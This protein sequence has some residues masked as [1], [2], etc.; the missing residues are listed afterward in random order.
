MLCFL[1]HAI[2][3]TKQTSSIPSFWLTL[4]SAMMNKSVMR[5]KSV[6]IYGQWWYLQLLYASESILKNS[7]RKVWCSTY[8]YMY[9]WTLG[10]CAIDFLTL[11]WC[12]L[13]L[14]TS[15]HLIYY[16]CVSCTMKPVFSVMRKKGSASPKHLKK[17]KAKPLKIYTLRS[18]SNI[19]R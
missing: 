17:K 19:E 7:I 13:Q 5:E 6:R 2:I 12:S 10:L 4:I 9:T 15:I 3:M 11:F 1:K 14:F 8:D 16:L 18:S